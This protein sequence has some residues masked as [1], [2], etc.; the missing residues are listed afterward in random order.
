MKYY[1]TKNNIDYGFYE[2][3]F[4]NAIEITDEYWKDL[5]HKQNTGKIIIPFEN[6][7]IAIDEKEYSKENGKWRKLSKE[8]T[9]AKQLDITNAIRKQEILNE[10]KELDQKRIRAIAEPSLIDENTTWLEFY[11]SKIKKLREELSKI[12]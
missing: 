12:S 7:V 5:L 8:E 11:N 10:L 9:I 1:G 2:E 6:R 3:N 4:K